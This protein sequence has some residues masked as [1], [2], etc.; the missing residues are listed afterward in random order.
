MFFN[1]MFAMKS[2]K[3]NKVIACM[4]FI[5]II[6][7]VV[8]STYTYLYIEF[9][10]KNEFKST[11]SRF[12]TNASKANIE[13]PLN[14]IKLIFRSLSSNIDEDDINKYIN[15]EKTDLNTV[16]P[17]ITDSTV[18][19]SNV[20]ISD[21]EDRYKIYPS[22]NIDKF[23]PRERPWYPLTATKDAI[24]YSEPYL[25]ILND[26]NGTSRSNKKSITASTNLYNKHSG[27]IGN[28]AFD[29]DLK[30]IS[31]TINNKLPPYNGK[32][33]ITSATGEVVLS[34]NKIDIFK[35]NVPPS[36]IERASAV[37]GDFYDSNEGVFVFYKTYMNPDWLAFTIVNESDYHDITS[38]AKKTFWIVILSCFVFYII[39]VALVKLYMER[40]ISRLYMGINGIDHKKDKITI[41]SI[42]ENIQKSK[43]NLEQAVYDSTVDSLTNMFNRRKFDT[44]INALAINNHFF[45]LAMIDIDDFKKINDTYGHET[46]DV[47]LRT[48]CKIGHQI[49][50]NTY[51]IYRIG[52]EELCVIYAGDDYQH[53]YELID[54]WLKMVSMRA[55]RES[56]LHVTFSAGIA[57]YNN[58]KPI[59]DVLIDADKKLYIAKSEGK[60]R[61][62]GI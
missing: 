8:I 50:G 2:Y 46:G 18:F 20:I 57:T 39:M 59:E 62:I 15:N 49:M 30:S 23:S 61:I 44:D 27:F 24:T 16:I 1:E 60:N 21:A 55:W 42:Y 36:W 29:L 13:T 25:S 40:I 43:K 51:S 47:V 26:I 9:S 33:F 7:F 54:T 35:K 14:E 12:T 28:I 11:M 53:F 19:F 52:G 58:E 22:V 41:G 37:E 38:I 10:S 3:T 6:P 5:L 34:E 48:V 31:S 45:Y 32:F 56:D 17:A 4:F